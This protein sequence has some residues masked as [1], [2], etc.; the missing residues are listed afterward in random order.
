MSDTPKTD[1][2][3]I[4]GHDVVGSEYYVPVDFARAQE[5]RTVALEDALQG[6]MQW[7]D[8]WDPNFIHDD[9]W[10]ATQRA[11]VELLNGANSR[12]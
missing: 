7:I 9:E 2:A 5:R 11:I 4:W 12:G 6:V 8:G 1:G 10:P 3:A